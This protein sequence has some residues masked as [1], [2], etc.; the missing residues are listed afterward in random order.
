MIEPDHRDA[1]ASAAFS[2]AGGTAAGPRLRVVVTL[3]PDRGGWQLLAPGGNPRV[4][5]CDIRLNPT[6]A[7]EADYW[8]VFA[9]ARPADRVRCAPENT[10]FIAAEPEEKKVYPMAF[11][12]QFHR[13]I[14]THDRSRHPRLIRHA[15]CAA[16]HLGFDHRE[17]GF[18]FGYD[19]LNALPP[20]AAYHNQVSVVCSN[21]AGTPGQR[22]RLAFLAELKSRLGDRL[23]HFGRGF[24]PVADKLDAILGYRYHLVMENCRA[25][26]YWTEKL[27]DAYLGWAFP[28]YLGCPN[29]GDYFPE[30]SFASLDIGDPALAAER[31]SRLLDREP[32]DAQRAAVAAG[33]RLVLDRYNPWLAWARWAETY[34]QAGAAATWL[35]I[36]SHKA[37]RPFPR[38]WWYRWRTRHQ[39][40]T[41]PDSDL[42]K[43]GPLG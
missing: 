31:I 18:T 39:R 19:W 24:N 29:L 38:G 12:R 23:V 13:L 22:Q 2:T 37:F 8:I 5:R 3:E 35:T 33:R 36:R 7:V 17:G 14:D 43:P 15:P 25:R 28:L 9:N 21:A 30:A 41:G 40:L 11:Y 34:H 4:G 20:P 10:L 27:A 16:W 6:G 32:D 26:D 1:T 42:R